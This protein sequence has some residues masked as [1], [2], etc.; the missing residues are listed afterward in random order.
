[1]SQPADVKKWVM[2]GIVCGILADLAYGL[3]VGAPLPAR[4]AYLLFFSFGPLLCASAGGMYVFIKQHRNSIPLQVGT[5]FIIIPGSV[6]FSVSR[7][8]LSEPQALS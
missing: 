1:M 6:R 5:L 4:L 7:A 2:F 3:S 8:F